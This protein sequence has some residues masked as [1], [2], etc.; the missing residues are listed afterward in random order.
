[1]FSGIIHAIS[2]I[3]KKELKN[4]SL[5]LTI[6]KP[7]GWKIKRGDSIATDG[8][9]LT[10]KKVLKNL[11]VTELMPET[12]DKTYFLNNTYTYVNLEKSL[13]LKDALDGHLVTGHVDTIGTIAEIK[14]RGQSKIFKVYFPKKFT[15]YVVEKGS[16]AV[17][18]ISLTVV[19]VGINWF[20]VSLVEYT[21]EHT[22]LG[23]KKVHEEVHL[24]FDILAK[25]LEKLSRN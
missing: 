8:V 15:K 6:K 24:E 2:K 4:D 7:I 20:T 18:G 10:V 23:M 19:D 13:T 25:Y 5:F 11:Y 3:E 22:I 9:C 1:M 16:I 12:L 21:L 14:K 17:D